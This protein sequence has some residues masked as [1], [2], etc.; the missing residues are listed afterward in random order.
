MQAALHSKPNQ[1]KHR[2]I[3]ICVSRFNQEITS[4]LLDGALDVFK[5]AGIP[6][7]NLY[8]VWVPGAFEIPLVLEE[9]AR[10]SVCHGMVAIGCLIRG[11]TT[12][13]EYIAHSVAMQVSEIMTRYTIPVGF[14]VLTVENEK[15]A[16]ARAGGSVANRGE[17]A[18]SSVL[19]MLNVLENMR[20]GNVSP[21]GKN[22]Y[23]TSV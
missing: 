2:K 17:E 1:M 11:E 23:S 6:E 16:M 18:A 7:T 14:G 10:N 19:D 21:Q 8:V 3:G 15:Q 22:I 9:W 20:S 4:R 5:R 13:Y 12:N